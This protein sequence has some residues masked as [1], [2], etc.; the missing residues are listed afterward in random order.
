ML[1]AYLQHV[2]GM[3][4]ISSYRIERVMKINIQ[5]TTLK[6]EDLIVKG[7]IYA[8]DIHRQAM[9][10]NVQWYIAPLH[11]QRIIL[12]LLQRGVKTFTLSVG[13]LFIGSLECCA[14]VRK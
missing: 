5:N 7:L 8:I 14:T 10:Y 11:I 2:C 1:I 6:N 4:S 3:L 13:G 12:I 9:K